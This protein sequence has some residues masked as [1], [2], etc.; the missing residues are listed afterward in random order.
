MDPI[1]KEFDGL[2]IGFMPWIS[3]DNQEDCM[4]FAAKSKSSILVSH[5]ELEGFEMGKNMPLA[6]HGL[7][8]TLFSRFEMVL[9]GHYHTKSTKNNIHY[10]G[11]QMELTWADAGDPKYFHT[12]D[13][14]TRELTPIRNK[15]VLFRRVRYNDKPLETITKED[16]QGT[17]VKIVVLSKKDLYEFD[18]FVDRIQ[19]YSP[20]EVKIIENFDEF[21]GENVDNADISTANTGTLLNTYVDSIETDLDLEKLKLMLHE[22]YIEAQQIESV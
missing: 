18:R 11:T 2:S 3:D 4:N 8:S 9:S 5:L 13:T 17:Y 21:V 19:S 22:L 20:F 15:H 7:N 6:T 10:L 1:D 12:L 16:I 14:A